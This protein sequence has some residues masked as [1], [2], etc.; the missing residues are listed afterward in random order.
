M[1]ELWSI[2][3]DTLVITW[4][5][6][7]TYNIIIIYKSYMRKSNLNSLPYENKIFKETTNSATHSSKSHHLNSGS[8]D[9]LAPEVIAPAIKSPP[10]MSGGFGKV[11]KGAN[12]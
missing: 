2:I 7:T 4:L 11:E 12:G 3:R 6:Y 9:L 5:F 8:L 10:K 1:Y